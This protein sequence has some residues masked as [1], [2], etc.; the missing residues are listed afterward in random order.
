[1]PKPWTSLSFV[2]S[3]MATVREPVDCLLLSKK[4]TGDLDP[5][6]I[7]DAPANNVDSFGISREASPVEDQKR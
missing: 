3:H 4:A 6:T 5:S 7:C 1:M 2:A